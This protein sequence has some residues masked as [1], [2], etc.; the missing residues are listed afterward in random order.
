MAGLKALTPDRTSDVRAYCAHRPCECIQVSGWLAEGGLMAAGPRPLG[1]GWLFA[2]TAPSG[3]LRALALLNP[4]GILHPV[5]AS[6]GLLDG[7]AALAR[8]NPGLIRVIVGV[9]SEVDAL[10]ERL[11]ALGL[12]SR[13]VRSQQ[14][15][16]VDPTHFVP[17]PTTLALTPALEA[18]L[19]ELVEASGAMSREETRDDPQARNPQLFRERI[20]SRLERGRDFIHRESGHLAFKCNVSALSNLGGQLEGIYT[21]PASRRRGYGRAGTSW[22]TAWVLERAERSVLLVNDDNAVARS[23]YQGLGYREAHASRTIFLAR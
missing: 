11:S 3:E 14:L 20:A 19:D 2:E 1:R 4:F 13:S 17:S 23:L 6:L 10:W 18:D 7:L 21:Q 8:A 16:T 22:I 15:M 5:G 12:R 9:R